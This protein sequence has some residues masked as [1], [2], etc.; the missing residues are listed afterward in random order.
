MTATEIIREIEALPP[1]EQEE[2]VR[3]AWRLG[4]RR[5]LSPGELGS[6]AERLT[7]TSDST[8]AAVLREQIVRGFYGGGSDA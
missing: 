5:K 4:A 2:V 8:E 1:Q 3:F 7:A 6:L